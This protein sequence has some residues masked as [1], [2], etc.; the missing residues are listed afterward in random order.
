MGSLNFNDGSGPFPSEEPVALQELRRQYHDRIAD[1]RDRSCAI[2][3]VAVS[4]T[5]DA[6][7]ALLTRDPTVGE[8]LDARVQAV[9]TTAA[10]IDA[11][12]VGVLALESP[13]AR[14]LRVILATRDVTQ[15]ALLCVGLCRTLARRASCRPEVLTPE[16][17]GLIESVGSGTAGLLQLAQGAWTALDTGL[18]DSVA[19]AALEVRAAQTEFFAALLELQGVPMDAAMDLGM[20]ARAYERLA[21]HAVEIADRVRF[22]VGPRAVPAAG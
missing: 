13:V 20:A 10:G 18:A 6:T 14:D 22:A 16:L 7:R 2:V 21:D 8:D 11:E 4:G 17:T 19:D 9:A 3:G 1:V 15:I 5:A 12:V